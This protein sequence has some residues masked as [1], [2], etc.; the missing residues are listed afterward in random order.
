MS[1]ARFTA[2]IA[3]GAALWAAMPVRAAEIDAARS[4]IGFSLVTR[5]RE[6]VDGRFPVFNGR[7]TRLADGRQQVRL[8]LSAADVEILGNLRHT[9]LTRGRG[10]FEA[11]RHPW[12]TFVSDPFDPALLVEGG[13]LP[14]V[15]EI[16][17]I[18]RHEAFTVL[19]SA[20]D[21][22]ALDCPVLAAG[23]IDRG[24]YGMT[25]WTFAIGR[26]V[27]FQLR[28]QAVGDVGG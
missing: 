24:D 7:L 23:I 15:L 5:W 14:G 8:A 27:R 13:A 12:I 10:F 9:H 16:R 22:P 28:I 20:C 1:R 26:K 21:R 3:L 4:E 6:V 25:R 11:E 2:W 17:D 18:Q 19:P